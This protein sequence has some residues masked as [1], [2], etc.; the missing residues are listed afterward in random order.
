MALAKPK[1]F[2]SYARHDGDRS[3]GRM[4]ALHDLISHELGSQ[5]A[6]AGPVDIFLDKSAIHTGEE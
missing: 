3:A 4:D 6:L 2:W 5:L 1:G